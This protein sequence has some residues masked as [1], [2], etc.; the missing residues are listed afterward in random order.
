[1]FVILILSPSGLFDPFYRSL[2]GQS[3]SLSQ[4][5]KGHQVTR[6]GSHWK[7]RRPQQ[8]GGIARVAGIIN[9]LISM[10]VDNKRN[11]DV[12]KVGQLGNLDRV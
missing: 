11:N 3:I 1:M 6:Q 12:Q 5:V 9:W 4:P 8:G 2:G 7:I 10:K